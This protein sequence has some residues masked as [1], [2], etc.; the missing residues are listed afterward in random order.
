M[1]KKIWNVRKYLNAKLY[2]VIWHD[3]IFQ[4]DFHTITK[5][6]K[7][8]QSVD[9]YKQ[10]ITWHSVLIIFIFLVDIK[11]S[12][13]ETITVSCFNYLRINNFSVNLTRNMDHY[14]ATGPYRFC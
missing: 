1:C 13:L 2:G 8:S 5:I 4:Q 11:I 3:K 14:L 7:H 12:V 6:Y 9:R 10:S